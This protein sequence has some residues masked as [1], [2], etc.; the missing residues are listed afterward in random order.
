LSFRGQRDTRGY[1][2]RTTCHRASET[3]QELTTRALA[4]IEIFLFIHI[5]SS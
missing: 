2:R 1:R 4:F 3:A 5:E